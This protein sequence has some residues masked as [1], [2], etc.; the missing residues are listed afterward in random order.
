[1]ERHP[2]FAYE[3]PDYGGEVWNASPTAV[4]LTTDPL[5]PAERR[6]FKREMDKH[7]F[8]LRFHVRIAYVQNV[9]NLLPAFEF[10]MLFLVLAT[11]EPATPVDG[12]V[13]SFAVLCVRAG[14][15]LYD[16][17]AR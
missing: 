17:E 14:D 3:V 4:R 8:W 2:L 1:M 9:L 7:I 16:P 11:G 5:T 10:C 15:S 12:T 6:C 13:V